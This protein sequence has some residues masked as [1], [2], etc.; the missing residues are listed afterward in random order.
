VFFLYFVVGW[1]LCQTFFGFERGFFAVRGVLRVV[2]V[3]VVG[4]GRLVV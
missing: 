2:V 4:F 1:R 3:E